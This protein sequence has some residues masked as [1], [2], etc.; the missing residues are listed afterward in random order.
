[1]E[2]SM[3]KNHKPGDLQ[4]AAK[5]VTQ[6]HKSIRQVDLEP[7]SDGP[8]FD[9]GTPLFVVAVPEKRPDAEPASTGGQRDVRYVLGPAGLGYVAA[10]ELENLPSSKLVDSD[11]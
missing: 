1:M 8:T 6:S 7:M 11:E 3:K 2:N 5:R 4:R 10:T 9:G